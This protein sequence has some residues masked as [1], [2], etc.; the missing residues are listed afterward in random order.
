M[1]LSTVVENVGT[2]TGGSGPARL[3]PATPHTS[4][5]SHLPLDLQG[6]GRQEI[7]PTLRT[8]IEALQGT[9][10]QI[11]ECV[12]HRPGL[13]IAAIALEVGCSHNNAARHLDGLCDMG[14]L[15]REKE[16]RGVRHYCAFDH[17]VKSR[18]ESYMR[19]PKKRHVVEHM[20]SHPDKEW[21]V[22]RL[23][24]EVGVYHTFLLRL[25]QRLQ[26]K[27][28]VELYR[29]GARYYTRATARL[30][31]FASKVDEAPPA[32]E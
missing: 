12:R 15:V 25:L 10:A 16:G 23:A 19:D 21:N 3:L 4:G 5:R 2:S 8:R 24:N 30:V 17:N 9:K 11:F 18:L 32:E 7:H 13:V 31:E 26:R 6:G 22:N 27:G 1:P 29:P 28:L 20:A 14:L